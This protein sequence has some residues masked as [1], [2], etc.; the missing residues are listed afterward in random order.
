MAAAQP[1]SPSASDAFTPLTRDELSDA[2]KIEVYDRE[3]KTQT[4]GGLIEGK[5]SLLIFTRHFCKFMN[6][7]NHGL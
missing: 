5:R 6:T 1:A 3:G 7:G 4:L 2:Q